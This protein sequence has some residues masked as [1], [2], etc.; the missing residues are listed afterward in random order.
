M[1][2]SLERPFRWLRRRASH[3]TAWLVFP[4]A[5]YV[6]T[7]GGPFVFDDL[8]LLLKA[9][10]Y[11]D[12]ES[13]QLGLFRFAPTEQDWSELRDRGV[14]PWW[15]PLGRRVDLMRPLAEL[16]FYIDTCLFGRHTVGHR[17][18][19]LAWFAVVLLT[20][21]SLFLAATGD[22]CLAGAATLFF[23]ISQTVTQPVT[24][25]C[26]RNDLLVL[27]GVT[28]AARQYWRAALPMRFEKAAATAER[29][30]ASGRWSWPPCVAGAA[31]AFALLSKETAVP[32][33]GVLLLHELVVRRRRQTLEGRSVRWAITAAVVGLAVAY[34]GYCVAT[35]PWL[36]S[37]GAM[38]G[39]PGQTGLLA[40]GRHLLLYLAVWLIGFP[41]SLL[42]QAEAWQVVI[43]A[44]AAGGMILFVVPYVHRLWRRWQEDP[45][46]SFF[47]LWAVCFMGLALVTT[48]E[49]RA[50]C[51]ATVGWSYL[52]ARLLLE[53]RDGER[54]PSGDDAHDS[55]A[56]D[57]RTR[58]GFSG[59]DLPGDG[60]SGGIMGDGLSDSGS[61]GSGRT[62]RR[63]REPTGPA[64]LWL[65]HGLL[66]TNGAVS[67]CCA[68]GAVLFT[69]TA[70][71]QARGS[72]ESTLA[73]QPEALRDGDTLIVARA[74][75]ALEVLGAADRL[76]FLTGRRNLTICYL[77][78]PDAE[79]VL[80]RQGDHDLLATSPTSRLMQSGLH[81]LLLGDDWRPTE[82]DCFQLRSFTAEITG[83]TE[84]AGSVGVSAIRFRFNEPL[85]SP[86]L[87]FCPSSL[88]E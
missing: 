47:G 30:P 67:I 63:R 8:N 10:R 1:L 27:V 61:T 73:E 85:A 33:A 71:M 9:E 86:R 22:A 5:L 13:Q 75:T 81:R 62:R 49:T 29:R 17:L 21:R 66:A 18:V 83:V 44:A 14:L 4:L 54:A 77:T 38:P 52:L 45:A 76:E 69:N 39:H 7:V 36:L 41:I 46:A 87:R 11:R 56:R 35:R 55:R 26:N 58:D 42:L 43:V 68:I 23:G 82:G 60:L 19:S 50:L 72:L 70:E 6:W 48:T 25:I 12:G 28:V 20:L 65:R 74:N 88:V 31:F 80:T 84:S 24:F 15:T 53:K 51:V 37:P 2:E 16:S 64:P 32:L 57:G 79:A 40:M 78:M 34:L 3:P 59:S